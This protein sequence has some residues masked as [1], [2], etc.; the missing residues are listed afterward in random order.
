MKFES[1]NDVYKRNEIHYWCNC[2]CEIN[3]PGDLGDEYHTSD[4]LPPQAKELYETYM[5]EGNGCLKYVINFRG[6]TAYAF[7]ILFH[8]EWIKNLQIP[9][10]EIFSYIERMSAEIFPEDLFEN[11]TFLFGD[12]TDPTGSELLIVLPY[13]EREKIPEIQTGFFDNT[14]DPWKWI[15]THAEF[16]TKM[17][18]VNISIFHTGNV[19][20]LARNIKEAGKIA[21]KLCGDGTIELNGTGNVCVDGETENFSSDDCTNIYSAK[22]WVDDELLSEA[23]SKIEMHNTDGRSLSDLTKIK[24]CDFAGTEVFAD[25]INNRIYQTRH[26]KVCIETEFDDLEELIENLR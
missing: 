20:I 21:E 14:F 15:E 10:S 23:L 18:N 24:I 25:L 4:E 8:E 5:S 17:F 6:K 11:C 2:T 1:L 22:G 9:G 12:N 3:L 19:R 26:G 7:G 13:D 16:P